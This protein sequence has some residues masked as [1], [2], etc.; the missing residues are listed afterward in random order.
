MISISASFKKKTKNWLNMVTNQQEKLNSYN[1][2]HRSDNINFISALC[3]PIDSL[4]ILT[5][6]VRKNASTLLKQMEINI[7]VKNC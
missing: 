6:I 7:S 5:Y 2:L 1:L 3:H 4:M